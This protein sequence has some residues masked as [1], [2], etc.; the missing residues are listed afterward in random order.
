MLDTPEHPGGFG[1]AAEAAAKRELALAA[2]ESAG[3]GALI[4][5]NAATVRWLLC[6]RG[7]P[8][9]VCSDDYVVVLRRDGAYVLHRDIESPRVIM[10]ER[11]DELG[12][13]RVP[14]PWHEGPE[15]AIA[16]LVS[17]LAAATDAE[18][19]IDLAAHR[20]TLVEPERARYLQ[21][22]TA[23]AV[24]MTET[25]QALGPELSELAAGAELAGRVRRHGLVPHVVLVAGEERQPVHRHPLPTAAKLGRHALLAVTAERHG[26][27]VSM[28]RLVSFGAAP[29]EL[30]RLVR[31]AAEVDARVLGASRPGARLCDLLQVLADAYA[32]RGFPDEWRLHHQGGLTGYLG[33]ELF[34]TPVEETPLP[35]SCAVAWNPSLTGGAKSEDTVLVGPDGLVV[36]T[37]T[38]DLPAVEIDGIRR[39]AIAE[40]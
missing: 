24:A 31:A 25:L 18:P 1:V 12:L 22:G 17:G 35:T 38:P 19:G 39:P 30:A 14:F 16:A 5:R 34:A 32:E 20:R 26:L 8:V 28:T 33:R 4:V 36:L 2:A 7:E 9:D 37:A 15:R 13:E 11:L 27:Y 21:A 3:F 6:G 10:E 29:P 40:L 23:T